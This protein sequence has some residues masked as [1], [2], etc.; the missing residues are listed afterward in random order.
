MIVQEQHL[1]LSLT[2]GAEAAAQA[3]K[4]FPDALLQR[5]PQGVY[6]L[7]VEFASRLG[8]ML[9]DGSELGAQRISVHAEPLEVMITVLYPKPAAGTVK[10][11]ARY[12]SLTPRLE[13]SVLEFTDENGNRLGA[14]LLTRDDNAAELKLAAATPSATASTE[15][16]PQ[17]ESPL[18]SSVVTIPETPGRSRIAVPLAIASGLILIGIAWHVIR[19]NNRNRSQF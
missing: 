5:G 12:L 4:E 8:G 6:E 18:A 7:P 10:F 13:P 3:L 2:L 19:A 16:R 11:V 9:H 17:T 1:E 15:I 14:G